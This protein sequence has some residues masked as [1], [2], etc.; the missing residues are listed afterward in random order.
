M[1]PCQISRVEG[2]LGTETLLHGK[3]LLDPIYAKGLPGLRF[4]LN[5]TPDQTIRTDAI[6]LVVKT[7]TSQPGTAPPCPW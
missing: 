3:D 5:I 4:N 1:Q 7:M 2:T 6:L